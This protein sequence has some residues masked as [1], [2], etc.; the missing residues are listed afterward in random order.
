MVQNFVPGYGVFYEGKFPKFIHSRG[1]NARQSSRV[2]LG[3]LFPYKNILTHGDG[4][5]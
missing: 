1:E 2:L 5:S 4:G 3:T